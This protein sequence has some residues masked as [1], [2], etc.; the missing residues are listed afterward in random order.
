MKSPI[1]TR[2]NP[3]GWFSHIK[4]WCKGFFGMKNCWLGGENFLFLMT[5]GV[6]HALRNT[7]GSFSSKWVPLWVA[8]PGLMSC[9]SLFCTY[10]IECHEWRFLYCTNH[11]RPY[12]WKVVCWNFH[13]G[14][15]LKTC[16]HFEKT[17]TH[18]EKKRKTP[19]VLSARIC[20]AWGEQRS[21]VSNKDGG[22]QAVRKVYRKKT[23][24]LLK[25]L[26]LSSFKLQNWIKR[27]SW[28]IFLSLIGVLT[29]E[30]GR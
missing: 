29:V 10:R 4:W 2:Q 6:S 26:T 1:F 19:G 9:S 14:N 8:K 27:R 24:Y 25:S 11:R 7:L 23:V 13:N 18:S 16:S 21:R 15:V 17:A 28:N 5:G 12:L 3:Y 20:R 22:L 30:I